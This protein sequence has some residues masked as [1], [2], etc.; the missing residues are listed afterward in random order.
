MRRSK[1]GRLT[2]LSTG[3]VPNGMANKN[4]RLKAM[5]SRRVKTAVVLLVGFVLAWPCVF[6][7]PVGD[8]SVATRV[9]RKC[10]D[11]QC[12]KC[13]SPGCCAQP[14]Q[15]SAPLPP[16]LPPST[17]H[18]EWQA[19]AA[20]VA[21]ILALPSRSADELPSSAAWSSSL[22]AIPL[23]QRDCCYLL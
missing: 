6:T 17:S 23:F 10:C 4:D 7:A 1:L 5:T 21:P 14:S 19:L 9:A 11:F 12:A 2:K 20:S 13:A 22:T 3:R 15:P 18:N 16:A 8:R